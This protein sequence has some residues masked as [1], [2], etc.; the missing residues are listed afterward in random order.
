MPDAGRT[1]DARAAGSG[2]VSPLDRG[3]AGSEGD[4]RRAKV[5]TQKALRGWFSVD[6]Q[7]EER[8]F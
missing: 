6:G 1:G 4:V 5:G 8:V 2:L 7:N 3:G